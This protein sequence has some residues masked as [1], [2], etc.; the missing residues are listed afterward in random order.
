MGCGRRHWGA[1]DIPKWHCEDEARGWDRDGCEAYKFREV[2]TAD[3]S[4]QVT[5]ATQP[6]FL[7]HVVYLDN[8]R[9]GAPEEETNDKGTEFAKMTVIGE[10]SRRFVVSPDIDAMLDELE[11]GSGRSKKRRNDMANR[12]EVG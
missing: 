10:V 1:A 11:L 9:K 4:S 2:F 12:T 3:R 6:S 5:A 7:Q 8:S